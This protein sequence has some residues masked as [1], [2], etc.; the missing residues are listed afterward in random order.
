[1]QDFDLLSRQMSNLHFNFQHFSP[2]FFILNSWLLKPLA[3]R[4]EQLLRNRS[5]RCC[6]SVT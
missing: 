3:L 2:Q 5:P 1:L 6:G 4:L